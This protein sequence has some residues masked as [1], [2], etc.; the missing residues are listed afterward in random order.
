MKGDKINQ[1]TEYMNNN[2]GNK[3]YIEFGFDSI[4]ME[5]SE[6]E[7]EETVERLREEYKD[8][9]FVIKGDSL[10]SIDSDM[11]LYKYHNLIDEIYEWNE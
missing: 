8:G 3:V 9:I 2:Q 5:G 6:E 10:I 4:T 11:E 7:W 1:I